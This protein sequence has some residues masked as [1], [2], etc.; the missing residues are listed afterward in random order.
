MRGWIA[1]VMA[2]V[3]WSAIAEADTKAANAAN[4]RGLALHKK[5]K[6]AE[7]AA[8]YKKAITEDP[9]HILAR[10]N[11][12]C[13]GSLTKDQDTAKEQ[14]NWIADRSTWDEAAEKVM[15]KAAKDADLVWLRKLDF[16]GQELAG[17]MKNTT[18]GVWDLIIKN[19]KSLDKGKPT[20]DETLLKAVAAAPGKHEQACRA[21][22]VAAKGDFPKGATAVVNLRDGLAVLDDKGAVVARTEPLGCTNN[23]EKVHG[24]NLARDPQTKASRLFV[25][26]YANRT[27]MKVAIFALFENKRF[28]RV[29]EAELMGADGTATL[30]QTSML[31]KLVFTPAGKDEAIVYRW[32]EATTKYVPEAP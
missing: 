6:Y 2:T 18:L 26:Q 29:F 19:E 1:V 22:A 15:M 30:V 8:E 10:Y 21:D 27:E 13:V 9:S 20:T 3:C 24:L 4:A 14:L 28:E 11:L 31:Y 5:K 7:A 17:G 25:V 12:A 32:D 23:R 16:E